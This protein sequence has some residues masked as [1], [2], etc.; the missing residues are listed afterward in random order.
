MTTPELEQILKSIDDAIE[1][2]QTQRGTLTAHELSVKSMLTALRRQ[3]LDQ[4]LR[5][6]SVTHDR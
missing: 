4:L 1:V 6:R 2:F 5:E 3:V